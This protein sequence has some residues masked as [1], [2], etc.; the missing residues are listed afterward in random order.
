MGPATTLLVLSAPKLTTQVS[1][2]RKEGTAPGL[3]SVTVVMVLGWNSMKD[4]EV[5]WRQT[6]ARG[7]LLK[8][9]KLDGEGDLR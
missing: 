8:K 7:H 5:T 1:T 9:V 6:V 2:F 3:H 4:P